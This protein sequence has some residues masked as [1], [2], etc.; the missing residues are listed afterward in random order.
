MRSSAALALAA[1]AAAAAADRSGAPQV[2]LH[3]IA[4]D[5]LYDAGTQQGAAAAAQIQAWVQGAEMRGALAFVRGKGSAEFA[6]L[7]A[8]NTEEFPEYVEE[9]AGLA[10]GAGVSM[11]AIWCANLLLEMDGLMD[12]NSTRRSGAAAAVGGAH[13][14]DI[15]ARTP[16]ALAQGHNEDWGGV[17]ALWYLSSYHST[18][19]SFP[20]LNCA[21]LAYPGA[22]VGWAVAW[23][24][25]GMYHTQ[26]G[27][28]PRV[29][30]PDGLAQVFVQ[31]R[32]LC[33][34][35]DAASYLKALTVPGWATGAVL[36]FVDYRA[37][38]LVNVEILG[39]RSSVLH[40]TSNCKC[41]RSRCVFFH[42]SEAAAQT[43][44]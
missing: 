12:G 28:I 21:G 10:A 42:P 44:T 7:K 2:P 1:A 16:S 35:T 6:Q 25:H 40:V 32:A 5:S 19:T 34:A 26:N 20:E 37:R 11:D 33:R 13:C 43:P 22:L 41:S 29:T 27:L 31:R 36:N 18:N 9:M 23:N 4:A 3:R 38:Q 8:V 24:S 17:S 30:Y 14:T 15:Y 39:S